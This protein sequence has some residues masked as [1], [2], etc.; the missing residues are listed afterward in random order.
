MQSTARTFR[1][2]VIYL[3][4]ILM[5]YGLLPLSLFG[6]FVSG[7]INDLMESVPI[8]EYF[9][10]PRFYYSFATNVFEFFDSFI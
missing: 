1:L 8:L 9:I 3:I 5:S 7:W 10:N 4:I 6:S 2:H